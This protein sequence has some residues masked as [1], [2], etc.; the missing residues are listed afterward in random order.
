[1][2]VTGGDADKSNGKLQTGRLA[3]LWGKHG[4]VS[5]ETTFTGG[6][7]NKKYDLCSEE[8][9]VL[10]KV[11]AVWKRQTPSTGRKLSTVPR[12]FVCGKQQVSTCSG[13]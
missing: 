10:S 8:V 6:D 9:C 3:W 12:I 13:A 7:L 5:T 11:Q 1:M 4:L 2:H